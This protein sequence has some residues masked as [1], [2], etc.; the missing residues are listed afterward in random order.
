L[1]R[2]QEKERFMAE[3]LEAARHL[4]GDPETRRL[5]EE[6]LPIDNEAM[7]LAEGREPGSPEDEPWW[8]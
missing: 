2:V 6:W 7:E 4:K 8:E 5:V 1:T 3:L